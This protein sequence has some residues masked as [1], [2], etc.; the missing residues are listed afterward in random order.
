LQS[1]VIVDVVFAIPFVYIPFA[2]GHGSHLDT[3]AHL[4]SFSSLEAVLQNGIALLFWEL[5]SLTL[6]DSPVPI[7]IAIL[8]Q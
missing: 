7:P 3:E 8:Y 1:V 6:L 5:L 2:L 4:L